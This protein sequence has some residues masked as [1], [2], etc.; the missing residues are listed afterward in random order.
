[1]YDAFL[2]ASAALHKQREREVADLEQATA[3]KEVE[4]GNLKTEYQHRLSD[5]ET[6]DQAKQQE[7][8]QLQKQCVAGIAVAK[9]ECEQLVDQVKQA[10]QREIDELREGKARV[11]QELAE[12]KVQAEK[13]HAELMAAREQEVMAEAETRHRDAWEKKKT[14]LERQCEVKIVVAKEAEA[15]EK[16]AKA[17]KARLVRLASEAGMKQ[18]VLVAEKMALVDEIAALR[19]KNG[20]L[21]AAEKALKEELADADEEILTLHNERE[22]DKEA[23]EEAQ[24][25]G[26]KNRQLA[27]EIL[28]A[29]FE[30][31][32]AARA[33][34]KT[35]AAHEKVSRENAMMKENIKYGV[36]SMSDMVERTAI[37][38][39]RQR[40]LM[41]SEKRNAAKMEAARGKSGGANPKG[42]RKAKLT[43]RMTLK[44]GPVSVDSDSDDASENEAAASVKHAS[45][46]KKG[47]DAT[48]GAI[49]TPPSSAEKEGCKTVSAGDLSASLM[50]E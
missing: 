21:R 2:A 38:D 12:F 49:M 36:Y 44:K 28:D 46:E 22:F 43:N 5:L 7:V 29:N 3:Q 40:G 24:V 9:S 27:Q 37:A 34:K 20:N 15:M 25:V 23:V 50:E 19:A 32:K 18:S 41:P 6:R 1:M 45:L 8:E 31:R 48:F 26:E 14:A 35:K 47:L 4:N 16:T 13:K 33:R 11:E 10:A 39:Q 30:E 42:V 17:E